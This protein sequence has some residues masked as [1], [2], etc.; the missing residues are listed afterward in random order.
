[1]ASE[2]RELR[3]L[4]EYGELLLPCRLDRRRLYSNSNFGC[5]G[6]RVECRSEFAVIFGAGSCGCDGYILAVTKNAVT[7]SAVMLA[8]WLVR[9]FRI[10][11]AAAKL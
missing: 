2:L 1:M 10:S 9:G 6:L 5:Q 7:N 8:V 4:C 3:K 11:P